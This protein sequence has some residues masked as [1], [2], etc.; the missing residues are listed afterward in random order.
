MLVIVVAALTITG[1]VVLL[2][3]ILWLRHRNAE[4]EHR[5]RLAALEKGTAMPEIRATA[6]WSPRVYLLRGLIWTFGGAALTLALL[7]AATING[8]QHHVS[9]ELRATWA[10]EVSEKLQIP[11]DQARQM[12]DK[13]DGQRAAEDRKAPMTLALFGVV[14]LAVGIAYLVFYYKD[15]SRNQYPPPQQQTAYAPPAPRA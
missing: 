12:V 9:A 11:I 1:V 13:D 7:G 2:V 4:M 14:P 10:R 5:E 15:P 8:T 3:Q 6:P